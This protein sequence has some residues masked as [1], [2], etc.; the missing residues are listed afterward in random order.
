MAERRRRLLLERLVILSTCRILVTSNRAK[1]S[2]IRVNK[3]DEEKAQTENKK[4]GTTRK[5]KQNT[6][7]G[8]GNSK[9][10]VSIK[11]KCYLD[12]LFTVLICFFFFLTTVSSLRRGGRRDA[13][14]A[15]AVHRCLSS[16]RRSSRN[17]SCL[18]LLRCFR[19]VETW[20]I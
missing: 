17:S 18:L 6:K 15:F 4:G 7:K 5:R 11:I 13:A 14:V 20:R 12:I 2:T 16:P 8:R 19:C 3:F 9:M 10:F 1:N